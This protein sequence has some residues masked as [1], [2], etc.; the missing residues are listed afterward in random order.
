MTHRT[1]DQ[2]VDAYQ[3]YTFKISDVVIESTNGKRI[4][5]KKWLTFVDNVKYYI[6]VALDEINLPVIKS[7]FD[8]N[9]I[10]FLINI[11]NLYYAIELNRW[12]TYY[13]IYAIP[14]S[15]LKDI[16]NTY[17]GNF[18][19]TMKE[20]TCISDPRDLFKVMSLPKHPMYKIG[21][22]IIPTK[23]ILKSWS[24][25]VMNK[26]YIITDIDFRGRTTLY[27]CINYNEHLKGKA[28]A[29]YSF[30]ES[31]IKRIDGGV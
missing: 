9:H 24:R 5:T 25:I 30:S 18:K 20:I 15:K 29:V 17:L 23:A 14:D 10:V 19:C 13:Y 4:F 12:S 26:L 31:T 7:W 28:N 16:E 1:W 21:D 8:A 27:Q 11:S 2:V 22:Y 6:G 3:S